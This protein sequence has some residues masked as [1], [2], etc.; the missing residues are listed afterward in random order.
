MTPDTHL[1]GVRIVHPALSLLLLTLGCSPDL[2]SAPPSQDAA[3]VDATPATDAGTPLDTGTALPDTG[4]ALPDTGTA[5]PDTGTAVPDS[6][7]PAADVPSPRDA[8][9]AVDVVTAADVPA[10]RDVVT[11]PDAPMPSD[12]GA[13]AGPPSTLLDGL[14]GTWATRT[15]TLTEQTVPVLGTVR[16]TSSAYGIA[17]FARAGSTVTLTE[18]A[19]RVVFDRSS[20]GTTALDDRAVQAIAP[21]TAPIAFAPMGSA[22]RWSR[23][24]RSVAVGWMP[25]MSP[26]EA[27]P[28]MRTDPRVVD[29]DGDGNPGVSV[30]IMNLLA[31]GTVYVVQTQ[32]SALSGDLAN[33]GTPRAANDPTGSVQ[34]TVG[35]STNLLAQDVPSRVDAAAANNGVTFVRLAEGA[36]CAAVT[37]RIPM[38]FP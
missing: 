31:S 14:V 4:T 10:P 35:A 25:R 34:R 15:R 18:R 27:L 3:A 1:T 26:D 20:L 11:V 30:R 29:S 7:V 16:T 22:W 32:R 37:A 2:T 8:M 38:L 17:V 33:D 28:T 24:A 36:D 23:A 19:C 13:P 5:A 6:G 9:P 12:S 21:A